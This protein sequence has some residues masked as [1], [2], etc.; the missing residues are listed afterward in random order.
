MVSN[1]HSRRLILGIDAVSAYTNLLQHEA[2]SLLALDDCDVADNSS[3][4]ALLA[5]HFYRKPGKLLGVPL[6][7]KLLF[8]IIFFGPALSATFKWF[9]PIFGTWHTR[10]RNRR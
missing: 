8:V 9:V 2:L 7:R 1:R 6:L 4:I 5:S 3:I 10:R